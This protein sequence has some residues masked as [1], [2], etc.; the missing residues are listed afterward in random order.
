MH[1][2]FCEYLPVHTGKG[3]LLKL[4][5]KIYTSCAIY[6]SETWPMKVEH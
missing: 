1:G 5:G 3:Y 6:G 2:K 4:N